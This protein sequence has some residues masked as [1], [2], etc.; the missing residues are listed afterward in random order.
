LTWEKYHQI[1]VRTPLLKPKLRLPYAGLQALAVPRRAEALSRDGPTWRTKARGSNR[2]W[3]K[4]QWQ[5]MSGKLT[6]LPRNRRLPGIASKFHF[7]PNRVYLRSA[8]HQLPGFRFR[9]KPPCALLL[10]K[11]LAR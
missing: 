10:A 3:M 8:R 2:R 7:L 5:V 9:A 11:Q 6:V 1:K 4:V